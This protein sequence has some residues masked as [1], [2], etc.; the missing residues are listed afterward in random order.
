MQISKN[1][2]KYN[3]FLVDLKFGLEDIGNKIVKNIKEK[4]RVADVL[5]YSSSI[6]EI[7]TAKT[8]GEYEGVYFAKRRETHPREIL[9]YETT[10]G[11]H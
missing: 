7:N 3:L 11:E 9:E 2:Y 6:E 10:Q 1:L 8:S 4:M 5:F